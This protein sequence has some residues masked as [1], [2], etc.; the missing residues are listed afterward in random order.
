VLC[1]LCLLFLFSQSGA[2]VDARDRWERTAL[3]YACARGLTHA[4]EI[5]VQSGASLEAVGT[6]GVERWS[7]PFVNLPEYTPL[8]LAAVLDWR[9]IAQV[10]LTLSRVESLWKTPRT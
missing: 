3:H 5:L 6:V 8:H 10:C 4:T 9:A 1:S 7:R 2:E